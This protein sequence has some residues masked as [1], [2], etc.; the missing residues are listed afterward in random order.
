MATGVYPV[1]VSAT[2]AGVFRRS[3]D[4]TRLRV[5][6]VQLLLPTAAEALAAEEDE[7]KCA[8][9]SPEFALIVARARTQVASGQTKPMRL[10]DL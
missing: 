1:I 5:R 9:A 6:V 4:A 7:W 3:S 2:S 10:E 8:F